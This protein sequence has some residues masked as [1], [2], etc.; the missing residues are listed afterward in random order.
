MAGASGGWS[1]QGG[2][3]PSSPCLRRHLVRESLH[4]SRS[5]RVQKFCIR[6]LSAYKNFVF[7]SWAHTEILYSPPGRVQKF[8]IRLRNS[9]PC[10]LVRGEGA[11]KKAKPRAG[12]WLPPAAGD[13]TRP[14]PGRLGCLPAGGRLSRPPPRQALR[15][16]QN[17]QRWGRAGVWGWFRRLVEGESASFP[18]AP[19]GVPKAEGDVRVRHW[20]R[21]R[22]CGCGRRRGSARWRCGCW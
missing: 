10:G 13:S 19:T 12:G 15:S 11:T 20:G 14:P 1:I 9:A 16:L 22:V 6:L 7:A 3:H 4:R 5:R 21:W 18:W 2:P 17:P 8:R